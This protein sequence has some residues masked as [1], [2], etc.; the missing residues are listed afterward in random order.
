MLETRKKT[1]G[2]REWSVTQ[3]TGTKT[4]TVLHRVFS[5]IGTSAAEIISSATNAKMAKKQLIDVNLDLSKA[6]QLFLS[7]NNSPEELERLLFTLLQNTT[8][9]NM[10]MSRVVFDDVF[11]GPA[12]INIGPVIVFVLEANYGDFMVLLKSYIA[13][14]DSTES[15]V[16]PQGD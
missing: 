11:A 8:V 13:Q 14:L 16:E 15:P 1:I 7:S 9:D 5:S 12:F 4:L 2:G 3:F 6:V 10:Q